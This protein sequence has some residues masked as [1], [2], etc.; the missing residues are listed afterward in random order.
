MY[1]LLIKIIIYIYVYRFILDLFCIISYQFIIVKFLPEYHQIY[2][3]LLRDLQFSCKFFDGFCEIIRLTY[4]NPNQFSIVTG[5]GCNF[6]RLRFMPTTETKIRLREYNAILL[7][8]MIIPS[9]NILKYRY[10]SRLLTH[11]YI[12]T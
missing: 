5:I 7:T 2:Y 9:N 12:I 4:Y 6:L 3:L 11:I 1:L 10:I 8:L